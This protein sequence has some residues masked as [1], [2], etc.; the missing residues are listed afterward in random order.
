MQAPTDRI[1]GRRAEISP[2]E[3]LALL[4]SRR[5]LERVRAWPRAHGLRD[6]STGVVFVVADRDFAE[7]TE[8]ASPSHC[9][10]LECST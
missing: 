10:G 7:R 8:A 1:E 3:F 4:V 9:T 5:S 6:R 2:A